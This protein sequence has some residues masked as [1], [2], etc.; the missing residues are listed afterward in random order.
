VSGRRLL[1][2]DDDVDYT[3]FVREFA[4]GEGFETTAVN[5][6]SRFLEIFHSFRPSLLLL[7]LNLPGGMASSYYASWPRRSVL[8]PS[9]CR[10]A[11]IAAPFSQPAGLAKARACASSRRWKSPSSRRL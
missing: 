11:S 4:E 2:V 7:D 1:I 3:E 8:R 10:A 9:R 6:S 5:E